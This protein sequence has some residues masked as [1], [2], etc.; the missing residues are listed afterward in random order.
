MK[1]LSLLIALCMLISIGGV[2][3]AWVYPG[4]TI[5]PV[6]MTIGHGMEAAETEGSIGTLSI[7][8][9]TKVY[10]V[11]TGNNPAASNYYDATLKV[12]GGA[13]VT[14]T[15]HPGARDTD[16]DTALH[17]MYAEVYIKNAEENKYNETAIYVAKTP[18]LIPYER[19]QK[20]G[21]TYVATLN[22]D[23]IDDLFSLGGTFVLD[24]IDKYNAFHDLEEK[25]TL[26][27]RVFHSK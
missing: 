27:L 23:E 3:A 9:S 7:N 12:E 8:V 21:D 25:L 1:K 26:S 14:F 2:Y 11:P 6:D 18:M 10:V 13:I 24:D 17:K 19:W 20:Q 5:N 4:N 16:I 22:V 15:P